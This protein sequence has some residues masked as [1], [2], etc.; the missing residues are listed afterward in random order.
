MLRTR[1]GDRYFYNN[2]EQ[3]SPF[4]KE[5]LAEINKVTL[6]R[7]FCDNTNDIKVMQQDVFKKLTSSNKLENCHNEKAIGR[8][9]LKYWSY[10]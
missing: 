10:N 9:N 8:L 6:A 3:P 7:I 5:Q 1:N 4:T 2:H